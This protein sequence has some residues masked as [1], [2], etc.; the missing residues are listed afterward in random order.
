VRLL[1][2][3]DRS[4]SLTAQA[5]RELYVKH[6]K[7]VVVLLD[8]DEPLLRALIRLVTLAGFKTLA[9]SRPGD[10]LKAPIPAGGGCIVLDLFM[11]EMDGLAVANQLKA[12]GNRMPL[13]LIT[14]RQDE[15]SERMITQIDHEAVLYKPFPISELL[16]A[17]HSATGKGN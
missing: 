6:N 8:D 10:L 14:G 17:I 7:T 13:I 11:P 4:V 15:R 16:Q 1:N 3:I 12:A 9:F 2:Q 5:R